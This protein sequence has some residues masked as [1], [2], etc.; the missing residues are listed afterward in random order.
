[1]RLIPSSLL[2]AL[3]AFPAGGLGVSVAQ[4]AAQEDQNASRPGTLTGTVT[5]QNGAVI[6]GANVTVRSAAG[7]TYAA[8]TDGSGR[9]VFTDLR[10]AAQ[11]VIVN[12]AGF[13]ES[14][15]EGIALVPG[16]S[17]DIS[18]V[19][20]VETSKTSVQVTADQIER[21]E[22]NNG[23][24]SNTLDKTEVESF[25]VN[26][27]NVVAFVA[28]APGVSNQ[29]GED[30]IKVG[31]LGSA[32]FAVNGGRTEYNSFQVDGNDVLNTDIAASH[33][34]STLM[35]Y[36]SVDAVKEVKVLTSNYGAEYGRSSS[37]TT[38]FTLSSGQQSVHG[39]VYEFFRNEFFNSRNYFDRSNKAPLYRRNDFGGSIGGPLFIPHVFNTT[40]DKSFIFVSE[41][42]RKERSPQQFNQGVPSDGERGF[43]PATNSYGAYGDFSDVCPPNGTQVVNISKYPD[44]PTAYGLTN[45]Y[46]N[47]LVPISDT[48][49]ALLGTGLIPR[50]NAD[51]GC[52][53]S[54][55]SCYVATISPATDYRQDLIRLDQTLPFK[56]QLS[57]SG[58]HDH[59]KTVVAVP[60]WTNYI[61]SFPTVQNNFLGPGLSVIA[62][63]TTLLGASTLNDFSYGITRQ[64]IELSNLAGP[65]VNLSRSAL[66][67]VPLGSIFT[68]NGGKLPSLVF[69]GNDP[70]YGGA[71][72]FNVDTSFSPWSHTLFTQSFRDAV[73]KIWNRHT[74][75]GGIQIVNARRNELSAVNGSNTGD[76]Q[77][78]LLFNNQLTVATRNSFADFLIGGNGIQSFQQDNAQVPFKVHYWTIEPYVQDDW[79]VLPNL[80][81][82]LGFRLSLYYNWEPEE[83]NL[84]NWLENSFDPNL[85]Q[86]NGMSIFP[87]QG[88]LQYGD[89]QQIGN[90]DL[91]KPVPLD[92]H[93]YPILYNGLVRCG[94]NGVPASC[95]TTHLLNNA[96]RVGFAW[97]PTGSHHYSIR[98][99]YGVFF[100]HGTGSEANAGSIGANPYYVLSMQ[101]TN[102]GGWAQIGNPKGQEATLPPAFPL[103]VI[104]ISPKTV[105]PYVQ[106]WSFGAEAQL[107]SETFLAL[108]YVGSKGTHLAE[109]W[110]ANQLPSVSDGNNPFPVGTPI[111]TENDCRFTTPPALAD[112]TTY[113]SVGGTN[114]YY[115]DN[116][117]AYTALYAACNGSPPPYSAAGT[118]VSQPISFAANSL[119][120]WQGIG[121]VQSINNVAGSVY[122]SMQVSIRRNKGPLDLVAS[123]TYSHSID[124]ASDRFES[125]F[126]DKYRLFAN[127]ASSD[128]DQR[129]ILNVSYTY[130]LP[131]LK[132]QQHFYNAVNCIPDI[133]PGDTN[134][135]VSKRKAYGEPSNLTRLALSNWSITGITISQT[136]APFSVINNRSL[137]AS[138]TTSSNNTGINYVSSPDN[139]GLLIGNAADSYPDK[140]LH[141]SSCSPL[142]SHL[143]VPGTIGPLL[144]NPCKFQAP[145]GLTQGDSGRNFWRNPSRTNFDVG[146]LRD[147]ASWRETHIQFRVDVFNVFNHTQFI[148]YDPGKGNTTANTVSCYGDDTTAFSAGASSCQSANGLLRPIA[149]H[150][151]RTMQLGLK[152]DF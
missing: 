82:N 50:A 145:R 68:P 24:V 20:H 35:V 147:F 118:P 57:L 104:S 61:N 7:V 25:P 119:R 39:S 71:S 65:G 128:F 49:R 129:H 86:T 52:V 122:H 91:L 107:P 137:L 1:M 87:T 90:P 22:T 124:S 121:R 48:A 111:T 152:M 31:V 109:E 15:T 78:T 63:L 92:D 134:C 17:T 13:D 38:L 60:Q 79:K 84:Y 23:V 127:R 141:N 3:L 139:A 41:E 94:S 72:G 28:L 80:T 36:P 136:G 93:S 89:N 96:P 99:G 117:T 151:P 85:L 102:P 11:T 29:T 148:L 18:V 69:A 135:P 140:A 47:N 77:G 5:D 150:R 105:W 97:D 44:C 53:S 42:F 132:F 70:A 143:N 95:Q 113:V 62:H 106:Q 64:K 6:V 144:G 32:K 43:N 74:L 108:S 46:Q 4:Q 45:P 100:E 125:N 120:P 116:P 149:A 40:K 98:G 101:Q 59:W 126:V 19:L 34:H 16:Q 58:V 56:S 26:G 146:L 112:S 21:I 123:Y 51:S 88:F 67:G 131:L 14:R 138:Y 8:V 76:I 9:F 103:D 75:L 37:G 33:G 142:A 110:Q 27:R 12:Q 83:K 115:K 133:D 55:G 2:F 10:G 54:E 81:L 30:E 114:L 73:T 66:D 130:K